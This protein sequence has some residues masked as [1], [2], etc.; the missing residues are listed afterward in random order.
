MNVA[1]DDILILRPL[2]FLEAHTDER[3]PGWVGLEFTLP[4][5][6]SVMLELSSEAHQSLLRVLGNRDRLK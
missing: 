4:S 3:R 2:Q 6:E 5:H 1:A